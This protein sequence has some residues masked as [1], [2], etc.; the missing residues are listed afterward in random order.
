MY[1]TDDF[2]A[3]TNWL[4]TYTRLQDGNNVC[5]S[6]LCCWFLLR[7]WFLCN[8]HRM[9]NSFNFQ[10]FMNPFFGQIISYEI[11]G[12]N[13]IDYWNVCS[14]IQ[15]RVLCWICMDFSEQPAGRD[16]FLLNI[17]MCLSDY[18]I[19]HIVRQ[20]PSININLYHSAWQQF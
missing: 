13:C 17:G 7:L 16:R 10:S 11:W 12:F 2:L 19:S 1:G 5:V 15:S 8:C 4:D 3:I 14:G 20:Q 9:N 6:P 18:T